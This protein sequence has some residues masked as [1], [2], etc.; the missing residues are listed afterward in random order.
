LWDLIGSGFRLSRLDP[1][2]YDQSATSASAIETRRV[3]PA[4]SEA[5]DS[6]AGQTRPRRI[7]WHE[8]QGECVETKAMS[9]ERTKKRQGKLKA[10]VACMFSAAEAADVPEDEI[11]GKDKRG[12]AAAMS[13][14]PDGRGRHP[15]ANVL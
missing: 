12:D 5:V 9:Y 7:E 11:F 13:S 10:E 15:T 4:G 2:D 14:L 6:R 1:P 8:D 3:V